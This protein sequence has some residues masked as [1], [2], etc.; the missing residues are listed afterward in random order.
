MANKKVVKSKMSE[1]D[2][3][4]LTVAKSTLKN[5]VNRGLL[6]ACVVCGAVPPEPHKTRRAL[7]DDPEPSRVYPG[8]VVKVL[9]DALHPGSPIYISD[10]IDH[11]KRCEEIAGRLSRAAGS[12]SG[13]PDDRMR[14]WK[15]G[16]V[17]HLQSRFKHRERRLAVILATI[18]QEFEGEDFKWEEAVRDLITGLA[19]LAVDSSG[20]HAKVS[21]SQVGD[22][23]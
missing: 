12:A 17:Y 19:Q 21:T 1:I 16:E 9:H 14:L 15:D 2:K 5:L 3:L 18:W 22:D 20:S 8:H 6:D 11:L 13:E 4:N 10:K 23:S 7:R